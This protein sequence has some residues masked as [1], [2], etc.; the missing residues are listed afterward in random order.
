MQHKYLCPLQLIQTTPSYLSHCF[1]FVLFAPQNLP[2]ALLNIDKP[3]CASIIKVMLIIVS[4]FCFP[5]LMAVG[6]VHD[7]SQDPDIHVLSVSGMSNNPYTIT[8]AVLC[9]V[10]PCHGN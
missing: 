1:P 2:L 9:D 6:V 7:I 4:A 10:S 5:F 3:S 8:S